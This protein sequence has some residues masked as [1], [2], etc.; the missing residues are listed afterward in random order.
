MLTYM[1]LLKIENGFVTY[2]Y[3]DSRAEMI[4]TVKMEITN[5]ENVI[6]SYYPNSKIKKFCS[7]TANTITKMYGFIRDNNFPEE[8]TYAC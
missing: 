8:Y 5:N 2:E 3:G 1:K 6:F 7:S 4:G